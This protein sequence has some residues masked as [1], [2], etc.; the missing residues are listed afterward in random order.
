[1]HQSEIKYFVALSTVQLGVPASTLGIPT[2]KPP[3]NNAA[4]WVFACSALP[5]TAATSV[6]FETTMGVEEGNSQ[7]AQ[8]MIMF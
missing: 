2:G 4:A 7:S 3:S 8:V 6:Q 5:L 1:M